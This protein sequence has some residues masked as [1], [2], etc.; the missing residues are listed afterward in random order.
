MIIEVGVTKEDPIMEAEV[1]MMVALEVE[2]TQGV[3]EVEEG[4]SAGTDL[5]I[6][7]LTEIVHPK[8]LAIMVNETTSILTTT[9]SN[10][11]FKWTHLRR[12]R[13]ISTW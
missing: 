6:W 3:A 10:P 12:S 2:D 5:V 11:R 7:A 4:D 13:K 8:E 9:S 1:E